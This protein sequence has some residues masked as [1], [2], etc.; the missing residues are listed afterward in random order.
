MAAC[1]RTANVV[2]MAGDHP[3]AIR[4]DDPAPAQA[5]ASPGHVRPI[6]GP[7]ATVALVAGDIQDRQAGGNLARQ[8][9][10]GSDDYDVSSR[11][12]GARP[13]GT[14]AGPVRYSVAAMRRPVGGATGMATKISSIF[15]MR[16]Q[17][18][19]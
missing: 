14:D 5:S 8:D 18:V 12:S 10:P 3:G 7:P 1:W 9:N 11:R 15:S 19:A 4:R 2:G 17:R 6:A 16:L 13:L